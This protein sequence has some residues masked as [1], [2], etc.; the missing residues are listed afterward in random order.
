MRKTKIICTLGPVSAS[1]EVIEALMKAGMDVVRLNFSHGT[2][3]DHRKKIQM[4][5]ELSNRLGKPIAILQDLAGPKL[6]IGNVPEPGIYLQPGEHFILTSEKVEGS[7]ERVSVSYGHLV[8]DVKEGDRILLADGLME[9]VVMEKKRK[10]LICRVITGGL[11]TSH[12][13]INLPTGT[14]KMPVLTEKDREDLSFGLKEEVDYVAISF[15]RSPKDVEE[16][17]AFIRQQGKDVPLIAKIEKHEALENLEEIIAIADG[18]MVARG[19][20]GVEIPLED[21]PLVQKRII[22]AANQK[23]RLVITA[24]QML[25][26]MVSSP[27]PTRAEATDVANAVIDG[28]DAVMLSEETATGDYPVEAVQFM[29]RICRAAELGLD[30][31]CYEKLAPPREVPPSV[32]HAACVLADHL[33]ARVIVTYTYSGATARYISRFRP[34]QPIIALSPEKRTVSALSLC[35]G[36]YPQLATSPKNTDDLIE[37]AAQLVLASREFSPGDLIVLTLGHPIWKAGTTNTL[38]VKVVGDSPSRLIST[39]SSD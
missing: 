38:Q 3:E 7:K 39:P 28:T 5:R 32:A 12:K 31:N 21:V 27:R 34:R 24:T 17:R 6:R 33:D 15:V 20:L 30:H 16:V 11:L 18:V 19:D 26:S 9:L 8:E 23:G 13:G 14:V 10:D 35:W 1:R 2:H 25:R 29:D 22:G 36:C 37:K 4:V